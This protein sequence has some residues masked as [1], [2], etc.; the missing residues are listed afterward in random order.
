MSQEVMRGQNFVQLAFFGMALEF[1]A[2][3]SNCPS[4]VTGWEVS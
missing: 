4:Q 2:S 3:R 1:H